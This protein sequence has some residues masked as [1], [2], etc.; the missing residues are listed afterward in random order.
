[1]YAVIFQM[2]AH[3]FYSVPYFKISQFK[4]GIVR[5][6][7]KQWKDTVNLFWSSVDYSCL[8]NVWVV[9][10]WY[11][12]FHTASAKLPLGSG[13][14]AA[15][16]QRYLVDVSRPLKAINISEFLNV[17]VRSSG[18]RIWGHLN[19]EEVTDHTLFISLQRLHLFYLLVWPFAGC[20]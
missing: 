9:F 16:A 2:H 13:C 14:S 18:S 5:I 1:M 3:L 11:G 19:A 15:A 10:S 7:A 4:P 12:Y 17:W 8:E 6:E 20:K